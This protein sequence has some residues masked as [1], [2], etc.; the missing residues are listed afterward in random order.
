MPEDAIDQIQ[1]AIYERERDVYDTED[2]VVYVPSSLMGDVTDHLKEYTPQEAYD[3]R[4]RIC[5]RRVSPDPLVDEPT[6]LPERIQDLDPQT[7]VIENA[8][9]ELIRQALEVY[10][11]GER[12]DDF[13]GAQDYATR[14]FFEIEDR[15][16]KLNHAKI[17]KYNLG[18]VG[19]ERHEQP[20]SLERVK[21]GYRITDELARFE[22]SP[23]ELVE[24]QLVDAISNHIHSVERSPV[25]G[26][27]KRHFK[28]PW[29]VLDFTHTERIRCGTAYT[30]Y[31]GVF[32]YPVDVD[33][34]KYER[35]SVGIAD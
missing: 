6:L 7:G 29:P 9:Y 22:E 28:F 4:A 3:K 26:T 31:G 30:H 10:G 21:F 19:V 5:G 8:P 13:H 2:W 1:T 34:Q 32:L 20:D 12:R 35:R 33:A 14:I 17:Q 25:Y 23:N 27:R 11:I 24:R 18:G 15:H 16:T